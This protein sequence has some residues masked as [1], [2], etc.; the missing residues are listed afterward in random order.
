M[1]LGPAK[2]DAGKAAEEEHLDRE[3]LERWIRYLRVIPQGSSLP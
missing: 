1:A 3:T 2:V